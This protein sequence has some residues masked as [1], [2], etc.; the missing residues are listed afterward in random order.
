MIPRIHRPHRVC[1]SSVCG[2]KFAAEGSQNF[3]K[4]FSD[5]SRT[6][7]NLLY[8]VHIREFFDTVLDN[9]DRFRK[10]KTPMKK[11]RLVNHILASSELAVCLLVLGCHHKA[12]KRALMCALFEHVSYAVPRPR[13]CFVSDDLDLVIA[14]RRS[15][16]TRRA[17]AEESSG[18]ISIGYAYFPMQKVEKMRFRMS[19]AVVTPVMASIG[20]R[21]Q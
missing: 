8:A 20:W 5:I 14:R 7:S 6:E 15:G 18:Q 19:S 16:T 9:H 12:S 13:P 10:S 4:D 17:L 1:E 21:A 3:A 2:R 11:A